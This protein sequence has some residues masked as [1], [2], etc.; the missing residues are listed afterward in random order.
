MSQL[1]Q[2]DFDDISQD[3]KYFINC[4]KQVFFGVSLTKR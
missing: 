1:K 4:S 3:Y 2:V